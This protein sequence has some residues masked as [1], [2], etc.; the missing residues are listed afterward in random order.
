M[1]IQSIV[2]IV[3]PHLCIYKRNFL[4]FSTCT[5]FNLQ[6]PDFRPVPRL[7]FFY[8]F[9]RCFLIHYFLAIDSG[10]SPADHCQFWQPYMQN[11]QSY[12]VY[13]SF[14]RHFFFFLTRI[15][16]VKSPLRAFNGDRALYNCCSPVPPTNGRIFWVLYPT[17]TFSILYH[18]D[19]FN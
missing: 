16:F 8:L 1:C 15:I 18:Y 9:V 2:V 3:V 10:E 6:D 13:Y 4:Q 5:T 19:H 17:T 11:W 12:N 7:F 14:L